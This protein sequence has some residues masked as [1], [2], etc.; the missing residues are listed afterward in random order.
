[1]SG[2]ATFGDLVKFVLDNK[3]SKT[4]LHMDN[5]II[6]Y[7]LR[8]GIE[9]GTLLYSLDKDSKITGMILAEKDDSKQTLLVTENLAMTLANLKVFA[10]VAKERWPTYKLEWIKHGTRKAY[11]QH[12]VYNKLK[13]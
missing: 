9:D 8:L 2:G 5:D 6:L 12:T 4:F 10:K 1:M 3:G 13:V 11:N 7:Y